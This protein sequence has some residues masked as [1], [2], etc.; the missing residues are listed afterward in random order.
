MTPEEREKF[1]LGMRYGCRG[2]KEGSASDE[3]VGVQA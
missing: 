2:R 1:K 3:T